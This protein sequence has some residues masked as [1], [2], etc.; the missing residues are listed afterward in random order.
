MNDDMSQMRV[1]NWFLIGRFLTSKVTY[2]GGRVFSYLF[3]Y[4]ISKFSGLGGFSSP[5]TRAHPT[6]GVYDF[7]NGNSFFVSVSIRVYTKI[8]C[9]FVQYDGTADWNFDYSLCYSA[10]L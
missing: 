10:L 6:F 2:L 3:L 5:I 9:V 7:M 1:V 4:N 8:L